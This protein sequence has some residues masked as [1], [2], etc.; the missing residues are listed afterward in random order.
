ME[1]KMSGEVLAVCKNLGFGY[2]D[3][4]KQA[5]ASSKDKN[6]N[7]TLKEIWRAGLTFERAEQLAEQMNEGGK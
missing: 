2:R 3:A 7:D 5:L 1:H 4:R 6:V